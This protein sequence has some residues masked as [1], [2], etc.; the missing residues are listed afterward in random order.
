MYEGQKRVVKPENYQTRLDPDV[1]DRV[2]EY[3]EENDVTTSE[4]VRRLVRAGLDE[5]E[6]NPL[7]STRTYQLVALL[8]TILL[9][10]TAIAVTRLVVA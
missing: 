4:G 1:A 5:K 8:N 6:D 2:D 7:L 9:V 3:V 10:Y